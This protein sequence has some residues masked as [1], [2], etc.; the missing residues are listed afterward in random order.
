MR[1][2]VEEVYS[3]V[4]RTFPFVM[5]GLGPTACTDLGIDPQRPL[6]LRHGPACP[7]HLSRHVRVQVARTSRAMAMGKRSQPSSKHL[8]HG[9]SWLFP[10]C[11]HPVRTNRP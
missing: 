7:G 6:P 10:K 11:V 8:I 1:W 5:A 2:G 9:T 4:A 3:C